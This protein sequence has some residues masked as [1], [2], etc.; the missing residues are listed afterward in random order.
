MVLVQYMAKS[1]SDLRILQLICPH[2]DLSL[3][4]VSEEQKAVSSA[5]NQANLAIT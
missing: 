2:L 1:H 4:C 5:T 3:C